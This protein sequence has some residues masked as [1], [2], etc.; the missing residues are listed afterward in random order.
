MPLNPSVTNCA[1][2]PPSLPLPVADATAFPPSLP[3]NTGALLIA[4]PTGHR[5]TIGS[6]AIIDLV[7]CH[8]WEQ[9]AGM[10]A[11]QARASLARVSKSILRSVRVALHAD[12]LLH[13]ARRAATPSTIAPILRE[14]TGPTHALPD[15]H[16]DKR[17]CLALAQPAIPMPS[18][19]EILTTLAR[20]VF[21]LPYTTT[22][23]QHDTAKA[24]LGLPASVRARPLQ[25]LLAAA[26]YRTRSEADAVRAVWEEYG[27]SPDDL[28]VAVME[29]PVSQRGPSL[30]AYLRLCSLPM[31]EEGLALWIDAG[32]A[33]P[34]DQRVDLLMTLLERV[35]WRDGLPAH[36][37]R[38]LQLLRANG[39][40]VDS[41]QRPLSA[42]TTL[43]L[44][45][46]KALECDR[47][48]TTYGP[49]FR[50]A[51]WPTV[52]DAVLVS[53]QALSVEH[54]AVVIKA[55]AWVADKWAPPG[56]ADRVRAAADGLLPTDREEVAAVLR[57]VEGSGP[58]P[59]EPPVE[60][61]EFRAFVKTI[62]KTTRDEAV[63]LE[64]YARLPENV[65]MA[66]QDSAKATA[67]RCDSKRVVWGPLAGAM[68]AHTTNAQ[69]RAGS[70]HSSLVEAWH[71]LMWQTRESPS[72]EAIRG[73]QDIIAAALSRVEVTLRAEVLTALAVKF[74][75]IDERVWLLQQ[76]GTLPSSLRAPVLCWLAMFDLSNWSRNAQGVQV[77]AKPLLEQLI[78]AI[79]ALP[80][81][82]QGLPLLALRE[83]RAQPTRHA[84]L[85]DVWKHFDAI[86]WAAPPEDRRFE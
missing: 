72:P 5:A 24:V 26:G 23:G 51:T 73:W 53:A 70:L 42:Q 75:N 34:L 15:Q 8:V 27:V 85:Q 41:R 12:K 74:R 40:L 83:L 32:R 52:W 64:R 9:V 31:S 44:K 84:A 1:P 2:I 67:Y 16:R 3:A 28:I 50:S 37:D 45:L 4:P 21:R 47:S 29:L 78:P 39:E 10:L 66:M 48:N 79:A 36:A 86:R 82:Y 58:Y 14:C 61:S 17:Q 56:T 76:A 60:F 11:P 18:R 68:L 55:M 71:S 19:A 54:R 43:L 62:L 63:I 13:H 77:D 49:E 35:A 25:Q 65:Q 59:A 7:P 57:H 80:G 6:Q 69:R 33:L 81:Q 22:R 20:S 30:C 46:V 38:H